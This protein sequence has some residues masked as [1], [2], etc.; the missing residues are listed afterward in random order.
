MHPYEMLQVGTKSRRP[1][2]CR[3]S[4][5]MVPLTQRM[6]LGGSFAFRSYK[7]P[8][9]SVIYC[10]FSYLSALT[11]TGAIMWL[12]DPMTLSWTHK[13]YWLKAYSLISQSCNH[14]EIVHF[15]FWRKC[16]YFYFMCMY[17]WWLH[18]VCH[19]YAGT[20]RSQKRSVSILDLEL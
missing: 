11:V 20:H 6:R 16:V 18:N 8:K 10:K 1:C 12:I 14:K 9:K 4:L 2:F 17:E 15:V 5:R 13:S 7:L 3:T 19:M